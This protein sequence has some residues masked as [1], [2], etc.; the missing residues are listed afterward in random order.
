MEL[1]QQGLAFVHVNRNV[2]PFDTFCDYSRQPRPFY[3]LASVVRGEVFFEEDGQRCQAGPGETVLIPLHSCYRSHWTGRP[4]T[5]VLSCYF[6][7]PER[8]VPLADKRFLLQKI[9]GVPGLAETLRYLMEHQNEPEKLFSLLSRFYGLCDELFARLA[10]TAAPRLSPR[11]QLAVDHLRARY[12]E[13]VSVEELARIADMSVSHFYSC[14]RQEVG[15]PPIAYKHRVAVMAAEQL[16]TTG[17]D[18]S[19]EEVSGMTGFESSTYFR[20][21]FKQHTGLSPREYR[22]RQA[23][24]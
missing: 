8:C 18:L 1:A 23:V 12:R 6:L 2:F 22:R 21:I 16:L 20:R 24:G 7:L 14:F 9:E 10:Y 13:P 15:L 11:I 4:Q 3:I 5:E 19:I 17:P